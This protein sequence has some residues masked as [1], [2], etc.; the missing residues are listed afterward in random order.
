MDVFWITSMLTLD[1]ST[2]IICI[3]RE[4]ASEAYLQKDL[5]GLG[6]FRHLPSSVSSPTNLLIR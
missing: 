4:I 1:T 3:L 6:T 5:F 2:T